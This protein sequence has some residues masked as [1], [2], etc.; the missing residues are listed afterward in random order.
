MGVIG[1]IVAGAIVLA[2]I[3]GGVGVLLNI[4]IAAL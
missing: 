4:I 2:A 3:F 1:L